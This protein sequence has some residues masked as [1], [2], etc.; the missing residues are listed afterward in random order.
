MKFG[1]KGFFVSIIALVLCLCLF[2]CVNINEDTTD[3]GS[4]EESV[5]DPSSPTDTQKPSYYTARLVANSSV[6]VTPYTNGKQVPLGLEGIFYSSRE[7]GGEPICDG[8]GKIW[9]TI[10]P[11]PKYDIEEIIIK[12]SYSKIEN[13][14]RDL[15]CIHDVK[16]DLSITTTIKEMPTS[17]SQVLDSFGYGISENGMLTITWQENPEE[18]LRYVELRYFEGNSGKVEYVD[19][20]LGKY[21]LVQLKENEMNTVSIRAIS[22]FRRGKELDIQCC[23]MNEPRNVSFPRVEI[24]TKDFALPSCDFVVSPDG[25]WGAGITN[26]EY[27]QCTV[28]IY[29]KNDTILF[30]SEQNPQGSVDFSGAKLKIRG[31]TSAYH[32]KNQRYPYKIKL[33]KKADLLKGLVDREEKEGYED[34]NWLLLNYGD[35]IY[36]PIGDSIADAV[37]TEWSPDYAYVCLYLNGEYKGLYVLSESVKDGN[38]EGEDKWR[39]PVDFD[40][41]LFECDAYWWNEDLSFSTPLTENTPMHFTFKY[42]NPDNLDKEA[43]QVEYLRNYLIEFEQALMRDDD[44]YLDYIDLDSFVKWLLVSD[45][46]GIK[47][48]GGCNL[49]LYKRDSTDQTKLCMGPNWDFD[50]YMGDVDSLAAIRMSWSTA[51]FYY[52]YLVKK[53]SFNERYKEL[54]KQTQEKL[55]DYINAEIERID[56]NTHYQLVLLDSQRFGVSQKSLND[57][58]TE[59]FNWLDSHL[60]YMNT[61]FGK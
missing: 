13:I 31:N 55:K 23:Y 2:S 53:D 10:I 36:R 50:F 17:S 9:L 57:R 6:D 20:S 33:D 30:Q 51:P 3:T 29:D 59:F 41:Y 24:T 11:S 26:A 19:G 45:Y 5:I 7:P 46:L 34:K 60:E 14:E 38:G 44:S 28:T 43:Y 25:C 15:Y 42:P 8:T 12:G 49:Y 40:G 4:T 47:D 56:V 18:L 35:Y 21:E 39:V 1:L 48:S 37:G 61:L 16:S 52:Q 27:E 32:E 58:K 54:F 22:T